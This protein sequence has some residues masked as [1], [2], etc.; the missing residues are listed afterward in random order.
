MARGPLNTRARQPL[1][2]SAGAGA[3]APASA[4]STQAF[5]SADSGDEPKDS[6]SILETHR[7]HLDDVRGHSLPMEE[8]LSADASLSSHSNQ[9]DAPP[10]REEIEKIRALRKPLGTFSQK[11]ALPT[12]RGYHRHWF[13]D[14]A[15]RVDEA[16]QNGW[17]HILDKDNK[18]TKRAVGTGRDNGVM[19]AYAME[20]PSVF[21]QEDMD[22]RH[23]RA[24]ETIANTKSNPFKAATGTAKPSDKGKFYSPEDAPLSVE[25]R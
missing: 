14:V 3:A 17:A 10:T 9:S 24:A 6:T 21:W 2:T 25:V 4:A 5:Y 8:D 13:N 11:L 15:G 23:A 19:Y 18:P 16:A 1:N 7:A 20:L 22:A 12:R